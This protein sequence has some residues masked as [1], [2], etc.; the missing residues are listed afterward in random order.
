VACA[1]VTGDPAKEFGP[2]RVRFTPISEVALTG[3]GLR[4]AGCGLVADPRPE[5]VNVN[6]L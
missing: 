6:T 3:M 5:P 2:K 4:A 1:F